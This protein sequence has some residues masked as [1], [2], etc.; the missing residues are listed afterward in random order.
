MSNVERLVDEEDL[1]AFVDGRLDPTRTAEIEAYLGRHPEIADRVRSYRRARQDL[2]QR[3][4]SP[5]EDPTP[6]RLRVHAIAARLHHTR[7]AR[8]RL[9]AAASICLM[10]G[11]LSGWFAGRLPGSYLPG[12][13][14]SA[15]A[16][17][18]V[19]D[20]IT[21]HRFL[22][23]QMT[24]ASALLPAPEAQL[25]R[26]LLRRLGK[27]FGPPDLSQFDLDFLEGRILPYR[28]DNAVALLIYGSGQGLRV[29]VYIQAEEHDVTE[30]RSTHLDDDLVFYW[31][32][33][34]CGYAITATD[35]TRLPQIAKAVFDYFEAPQARAVPPL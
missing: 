21:A 15:H 9:V 1:Q 7:M 29:T 24:P 2:K 32:D 22:A 26:W 6:E 33:R 5:A 30:L 34:R 11:F 17:A 10:V 31:L 8:Y 23:T 18:L 19:Q 28:Q 16:N 4:S 12:W 35:P 27:P 20:A 3:L 13:V 14:R 25:R